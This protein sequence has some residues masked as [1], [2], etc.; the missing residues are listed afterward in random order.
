MNSDSIPTTS[1][2]LLDTFGR[3]MNNFTTPVFKWKMSSDET[4]FVVESYVVFGIGEL[5]PELRR[6]SAGN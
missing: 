1:P 3:V 6:V 4:K 5:R 2:E